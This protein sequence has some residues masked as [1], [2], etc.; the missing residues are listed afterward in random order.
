MSPAHLLPL[1]NLSCCDRCQ[2]FSAPGTQ[3]SQDLPRVPS[4]IP[5]RAAPL[6]SHGPG[7]AKDHGLPPAQSDN[8][9]TMHL[10][11]ALPCAGLSSP[12]MHLDRTLRSFSWLLSVPALHKPGL[13]A[14]SHDP[15]SKR[16][17][18][19]FS[20]ELLWGRTICKNASVLGFSYCIPAASRSL[21]FFN[22]GLG[23]R[24]DSSPRRYLLPLLL[25]VQSLQTGSQLVRRA[26]WCIVIRARHKRVWK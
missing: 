18:L 4:A 11:I 13:G 14:F 15:R 26:A 22:R 1:R 2:C 9:G 16:S 21:C 7:S 5:H 19:R 6:L 25:P 10:E 23:T 3:T 20:C 12:Q 8:F 17:I 24:E